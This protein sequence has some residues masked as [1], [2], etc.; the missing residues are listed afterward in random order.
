M[1][2]HVIAAQR[3]REKRSE[4]KAQ[5]AQNDQPERPR[6]SKKPRG[7]STPSILPAPHASAS[8]TSPSPSLEYLS[9]SAA[10]PD[11]PFMRS[12]YVSWEP[13]ALQYESVQASPSK[14][15]ILKD[16]RSRHARRKHAQAYR[17]NND[18]LPSLLRPFMKVMRERFSKS[19]S[20]T[21]GNPAMCTCGKKLR[22]L[23][24]L[25]VSMERLENIVLEV[26]LC[27]TAGIQLIERRLFSLRPSL[28]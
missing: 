20:S 6:P 17:W 5:K 19:A 4:Q 15:Q 16:R 25:C 22:S 12:E 13:L 14:I 21:P 24:V 10:T 9:S 1:I 11:T 7:S 18:V 27:R 26:C 28:S 8:L 2:G 23:K 3:R